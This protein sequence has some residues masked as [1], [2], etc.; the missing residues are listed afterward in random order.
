M[1]G[2]VEHTP[3]AEP[4]TRFNRG[5]ELR[6]WAQPAHALAKRPYPQEPMLATSDQGSVYKF[7]ILWKR[8]KEKLTKKHELINP[9]F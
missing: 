8:K 3:Q 1:G 7:G 2:P 9:F 6:S 5:V 4:R